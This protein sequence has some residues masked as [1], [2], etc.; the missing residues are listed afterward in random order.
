L[1]LI[2]TDAQQHDSAVEIVAITAVAGNV[3]V[4]AVTVNVGRV[5]EVFE[6]AHP[7]V[8]VPP[9]FTGCDV[10]LLQPPARATEWHGALLCFVLVVKLFFPDT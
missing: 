6:E 4:A 8:K 10:P 3:D 9:L 2:L 7:G 1:L 5:L